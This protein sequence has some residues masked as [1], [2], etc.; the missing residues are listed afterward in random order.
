[1]STPA[2]GNSGTPLV[3]FDVI[4]QAWELYRAQ[5]G[6]WAINS[7]VLVLAFAA[8]S[9]AIDQVAS[10]FGASVFWAPPRIALNVLNSALGYTVVGMML[11]VAVRHVRGDT[12]T[13]DRLSEVLPKIG[14]LFVASLV[15]G[16]INAAAFALCVLPGLVTSGLLMFTLPLIVDQDAEP[17]EAL[18]RSFEMLKTQW[19][20]AALFH[21]VAALLGL[22][23]I[24]ACGVGVVFT[25][26]LFLLSIALQYV[27]F[28]Q[29]GGET[30]E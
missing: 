19:L 24:V 10:L 8:V 2:M 16:V 28:T 3:R 30:M 11:Y 12:P 7:L 26:P 23:G 5:L 17:I 1:M 20:M 4:G 13:L 6:A 29:T 15:M 22:V 9:V 21:F 18:Q 25:V 27:Q 14:K